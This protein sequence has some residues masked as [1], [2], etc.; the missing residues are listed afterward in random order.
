M[1]ATKRTKAQLRKEAKAIVKEDPELALAIAEALD[2]HSLNK[3]A[4]K[5]DVSRQ[6]IH[7]ALTD[8]KLGE[9]AKLVI[10]TSGDKTQVFIPASEVKRLKKARS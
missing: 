7:K 9:V 4:E 1:S 6:Y 8:G 10:P 5:L 3:A 2:L